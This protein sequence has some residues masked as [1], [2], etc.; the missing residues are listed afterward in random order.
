MKMFFHAFVPAFSILLLAGCTP[1]TPQNTTPNACADFAMSNFLAEEIY[2]GEPGTVN[3]EQNSDLSGLQNTIEE[4]LKNRSTFAGKYTIA[5]HTCGDKC[6]NHILID[7]ETGWVVRKNIRSEYGVKYSEG[8]RVLI[9]NPEENLPFGELPETLR[10]QYYLL[11]GGNDDV[12]LE[13]SLAC[14]EK[15]M[16]KAV[17][18]TA[19]QV[20]D[21]L[22]EGDFERT[23]LGLPYGELYVNGYTEI[24]EVTDHLCQGE[25]CEKYNLVIFNILETGSNPF[26]GFLREKQPRNYEGPSKIILGCKN[27]DTIT[28]S[29]HSDKTDMQEYTLDTE[30]SE[31]ILNATPDKPIM[32]KLTKDALPSE[33]RAPVCYSHFRAVEL[34]QVK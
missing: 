1:Q 8:S 22:P 25:G 3:F 33:A 11:E 16:Q 12:A 20:T 5:S 15:P 31:Q 7:T 4:A 14:E 23:E 13:F 21:V 29:N 34:Y 28:Y 26:A 6:Q 32:L 19:T 9:V 24:K 18:K 10:T 17:P 30:L 27:T 2:A